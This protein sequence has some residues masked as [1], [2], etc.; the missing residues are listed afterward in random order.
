LWLQH[1]HP[2]GLFS[3]VFVKLLGKRRRFLAAGLSVA[4]I[5]LYTILVGAE[6]TVVCAALV[7]FLVIGSAADLTPLEW[8]QAWKPQVMLLS[9]GTGDRRA[10]P[11][12]EVLQAVQGYTL[13]R[14]DYNN[15]MPV[16]PLR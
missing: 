16:T 6:A 9:V 8:L 11:A 13:L 14:S 3:T 4:A 10:R 12:P 2:G 7:D 1:Y 5:G 15:L